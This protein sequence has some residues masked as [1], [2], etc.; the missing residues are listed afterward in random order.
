MNMEEI[1]FQ[2]ISNV[3]AARSNYIEAI[4]C[5]K[6]GQL[7]KAHSLVEEGE[8]FYKQA[9]HVHGDLVAKDAGDNKVDLSLILMHAEDQLMSTETTKIY[10]CEF[11]D[12]YERLAKSGSLEYLQEV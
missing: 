2:I 9:H 11:I 4:S 3:G 10:A 8:E 5:A 1:C 7:E 6:K 12:L